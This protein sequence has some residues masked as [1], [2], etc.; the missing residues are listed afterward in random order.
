MLIILL[1]RTALGD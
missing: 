1:K